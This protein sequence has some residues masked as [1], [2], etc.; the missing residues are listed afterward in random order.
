M[1]LTRWKRWGLELYFALLRFVL[2]AECAICEGTLGI[3]SRSAVCATCWGGIRVLHPPFCPR[4]GRPFW[5]RALAHPPS[6][7]CQGCRTRPPQ[8]LLARSAVLY[9]RDDPLR[10][11][12]LLFKHGRRIG[13]GGHLGRLMAER[14]EHLFGHPTIDVIVPVP[15]HRRRE[16]DRGFNQADVLASAVARR[17]HRPVLRKGVQRIRPTPPQ[18]GKVRDRVRNV[19]GAFAVRSPAE[20]EGRSLLLVDDILTTGATVNECAKVLMKAGAR[21][22]LVYTLARAL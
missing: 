17:L 11:F 14:T 20:I 22:V 19:R 5:G 2:P 10:E 1:E 16:R 15:L 6:H 4:C 9:E 8:Y 7:L 21:A 3:G 13:L 12:L 18:A